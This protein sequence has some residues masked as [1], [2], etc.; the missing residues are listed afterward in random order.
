M[1]RN[2]ASRDSAA[3]TDPPPL[4]GVCRAAPG[5]IA[6]EANG[7]AASSTRLCSGCFARRVREQRALRVTPIEGVPLQ[8][9]PR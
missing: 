2:S 9:R 7:I 1:A 8:P 3:P 5:T 4:C 6:V